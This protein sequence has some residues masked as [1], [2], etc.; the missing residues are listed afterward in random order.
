MEESESGDQITFVDCFVHQIGKV[1]I[2]TDDEGNCTDYDP[3]WAVDIIW[4]GDVQFNELCVW[5]TPG[6]AVHFFSG[7][8]SNYAASYCQH[9]PEAEYCALAELTE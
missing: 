6:G 2:A 8:E 7:L 3:R 4:T 9:N 1:C 5:P